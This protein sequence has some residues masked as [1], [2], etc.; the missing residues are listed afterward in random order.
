MNPLMKMAIWMTFLVL[1][2]AAAS[3]PPDRA[4]AQPGQ[5]EHGLDWGIG[6]VGGV[7]FFPEPGELVIEVSKRDRHRAARHTDLRAILVGPDRQVLADETI[8]FDG[9]AVR[10]GLGPV[11]S[12]TLSAQVTRRGV[13]G[14]NI[15]ANEDRY[16][17]DISWGFRTN[18]AHYVVE[19]SRGHRDARHSEPIV[20]L[21]PDRPADVAFLPR[22]SAFDIKVSDLAQNVHDVPVF[23]HEDRQVA[24]LRVKDGTASHRFDADRSRGHA[25][26]RLHLSRAQATIEV[27]GTTIWQA[28]DPAQHMACWSPEP[29]SWFPHVEHRWLLQ[30]YRHLAYGPPGSRRS[31]E[32]TLH[33]NSRREKRIALELEFPG[34]PWAAELSERQ[35]VIAARS[36]A[37]VQLRYTIPPLGNEQIVHVRATPAHAGDFTTY[38]TLIARGGEAPAERPLEMPIVLRPYEHENAQ[39]GYAPEYSTNNQVYF[40]L[41]NRP[42]VLVPN[43]IAGLRDG[44][45]TTVEFSPQTVALEPPLKEV[46]QSIV[47]TKIAFDADNDLYVLAAARSHIALLH[48]SDG[49]Q[50]FR[51]WPVVGRENER[52]HFDIEQFSGHNHPAGPPP[53]VRYTRTDS[54]AGKS[55]DK[56]Q[57]RRVFWRRVND[58]DLF[59]PRKENGHI[60]IGKP[61]RVTEMGLGASMHSGPAATIVSRGDKVHVC[62]G[63]ATDP[64]AKVPGVP[65]FVAT[66][67]RTNGT[68]SEPALIGYGPPANDVHNTPSITMDSGGYLHAIVGTHGRPFLYARSLQANDAAGGWTEPAPASKG[69]RQTYVGM[70]CGADDTLHLVF[71]LW[72]S[73]EE[74]FP[75]SYHARLAYQRKPSA[76]EWEP[77]V[78]LVVPPFSEYSVYRHRLT[79]DRQGA[80]FLSYDYWS[81]YWFYRN[82]LRTRQRAVLTSDD[83]GHQWRL[84]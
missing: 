76:G 69:A 37:R 2:P 57:D 16:G 3:A 81:T 12:V 50:T 72:H 5:L 80:L 78:S 65:A 74:P 43:G 51:A 23:D 9:Q 38:A 64:D 47:S 52:R 63:E 40:D 24:V 46:P 27:E 35:A 29:A 8:P 4:D 58:L 20:L 59:V 49:G 11:Q 33:N 10:S 44:K 67:D 32:L 7:Y 73:G 61:I 60:V 31:F 26:W 79:I 41:K 18:C 15:T 22:S 71:R 66:Y 75:A 6:G 84:W 82:D 42:F 13:Y 77:P 30:P 28:N 68:L 14:L 36:T 70:A 62:W 1:C 21:R 83:S 25:P 39:F 19:T 45:W 48:S 55:L 53:F 54:N 56:N 17:N 34:Q